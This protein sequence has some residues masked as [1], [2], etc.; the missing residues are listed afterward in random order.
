[1]AGADAS[2]TAGP[3]FDSRHQ[4]MPPPA[5][6]FDGAC[7]RFPVRVYWEDTDG[8]GILY[9]ASY[10]RF[11]ERA[12]TEMLRLTGTDQ[13]S[14]LAR[15]GLAF[16]V[17]RCEVDFP[18]PAVMDDHL[19]VVTQVLAV[20]NATVLL[21]Q[22]VERGE[23]TLARLV[24]KL[25]CVNRLGRPVRLPSMIKAALTRLQITSAWDEPP[26]RTGF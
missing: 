18:S 6:R 14:L 8:S 7:H 24:I 20:R 22:G 3:G 16:P 17:R 12:R 19:D 1:M 5:G 26:R 2:G 21:D 10:L 11:A 15:D 4:S 13:G 25:A 9:H 23:K